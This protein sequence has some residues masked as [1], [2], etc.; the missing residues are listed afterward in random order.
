MSSPQK[1]VL[2]SGPEIGLDETSMRF[3]LVYEGPLRPTGRDPVNGQ[4][5]PLAAHKH[6]IRQC[7]HTQLKQLWKTDKFLSTYVVDPKAYP[8]PRHI[9]DTNAYWGDTTE[10]IP[11][12]EAVARQFPMFGYRF[13]PLVQKQLSLLC[14][15]D[16]LFLR[17]DIPGSVISAGDIDNRLKSLIDALRLPQNASELVGHDKPGTDEDPFF[18]LM[19]DDNQVSRLTVETDTLLDPS[20]GSNVDL[21]RA[22]VIVTVDLRPYYVTNLNLSFGGS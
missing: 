1:L 8:N 11:F 18:C 21:S 22:R 5:D 12:A 19:Q 14:G 17:R 13:V 3:R 2:L 20:S 6:T 10:K 15:L 16:I 9:S 7:F 4:S